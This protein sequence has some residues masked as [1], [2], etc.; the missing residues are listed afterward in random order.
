LNKYLFY[1]LTIIVLRD[2]FIDD[3]RVQHRRGAVCLLRSGSQLD[4]RW[5]IL[6]ERAG[7]EEWEQRFCFN[8]ACTVGTWMVARSCT[9]HEIWLVASHHDAWPYTVADTLPV[10]LC[11]GDDLLTIVELEGG[12]SRSLVNEQGPVFDFLRQL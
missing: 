4:V 5:I 10:C 11:C 3:D 9:N 2:D 12:I 8:R 6:R 1:Q 7:M